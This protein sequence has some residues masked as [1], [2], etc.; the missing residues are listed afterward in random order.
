MP[1]ALYFGDNLDILREH[2]A[3]DSVDLIYLDPPFNSNANYNVLFKSPAGGRSHAQI[4][5]F[6][7]TWHWAQEAEKEFSELLHQS[8]TNVS[9]MIQALRK[10]LGENDMMAYLTMMAT[11]LLELHRVLKETGSIYLHCDPTASHYLKIVLDGV[12]GPAN[13]RNDIVWRRTGSHNSAKRY[14]PIHDSLLFYSKSDDYYFKPVFRP[15][16]QGHVD[17]YFK[18]ADSKGRYW[19][20]ALTG[21][22]VRHG[23]SGAVWKGFDPTVRK[24]HWAIPGKLLEDLG[25]DPDA[26]TLAKLN[27]LNDAG[28]VELPSK[29]SDAMPT[30]K[31]YLDSSPGMPLQDIWAY[32]P[33]T[34]GMLWGANEG[35]DEDVR[36][37]AA[38]GD[39]ERLGFPTQK[40]LGLLDRLIR[41]SSKEGD[42]VLDPFCGC[43]TAVHAAQRLQRQW[44][45]I[46]ITNLAISLIEK[47]LRDAFP[48]I[49]YEVHG[50]PKDVEGAEKLAELDKYQFQWWACSLVNAQ[51]WR[52]KKKG[53][54]SGIDGIIYFQDDRGPAKKIIVSVKGGENV[55]APMV[56]DL[57]AVVAREKAEIGLFVTLTEPTKPMK[58]EATK[59]GF[60]DSPVGASFPKI[61]ILTIERLLERKEKPLY[62]DLAMGGHTFKKAKVEQGDQKQGKLL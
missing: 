60:Y 18:Q 57:T 22:G 37:L 15:Y 42:F 2:I 16:L 19:M 38:Q 50:T 21:A 40:P 43:G 54:D 23:E 49:T 10:F 11:R 29:N 8:N 30:Y 25:L 33:H 44:I 20:N 59:A 35:I 46:D 55:G 5:A 12:F 58:T 61:Q 47:R 53:A 41:A 36:W 3:D 13:F 27:A 4:E 24:R 32:Q 7:D 1:N 9:E 39:S 56:R 52:G 14:G 34:R 48:G 6:E 45:G 31:Q 17:S 62:P 26:G 51:P 28:F